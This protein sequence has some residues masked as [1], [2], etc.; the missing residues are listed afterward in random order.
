MSFVD[1]ISSI[2]FLPL[3]CVSGT[4]FP[5]FSLTE[6]H[7][8]NWVRALYNFLLFISSLASI[9]KIILSYF[10]FCFLVSTLALL[11]ITIWVNLFHL[12]LLNTLS[13]Y[14]IQFQGPEDLLWVFFTFGMHTLFCM[15]AHSSPSDL[16]S[17]IFLALS[18][19][20]HT[21]TPNLKLC[22]RLR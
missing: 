3:R 20:F 4:F 16:S 18:Y 7:I 11:W 12:L 19:L 5:V 6:S 2:L 13:V 14:N 15:Y 9:I 8:P 22:K 17:T 10:C 1:Q 21:L